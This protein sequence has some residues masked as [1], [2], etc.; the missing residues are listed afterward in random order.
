MTQ[1]SFSGCLFV[2]YLCTSGV[3]AE[4]VRALKSVQGHRI[5]FAPLKSAPVVRGDRVEVI[6]KIPGTDILATAA[7][8]EVTTVGDSSITATLTEISGEVEVGQSVRIVSDLARPPSNSLAP[9]PLESTSEKPD[10]SSV[11]DF[12]KRSLWPDSAAESPA[13]SE[14]APTPI[15]SGSLAQSH[16]GADSR[17]QWLAT[18]LG[19]VTLQH[20]SDAGL[21]VPRGMR[22][23]CVFSEAASGSGKFQV[24]DVVLAAN[25]IEFEPQYHWRR[26]ARLLSRMVQESPRGK[27]MT[28]RIVRD[29]APMILQIR[30]VPR[31]VPEALFDAVSRQAENG[32]PTAQFSLAQFL[33]DG[34]GCKPDPHA[35]IEWLWKSA[36]QEYQPALGRLGECYLTGEGVAVEQNAGLKLLTQA[37]E[38]GDPMFMT[39]LADLLAEGKHLPADQDA[40]FNW[41]YRAALQDDPDAQRELMEIYQDAKEFDEALTWLQKAAEQGDPTC[42]SLLGVWHL[43][44]FQV[45]K[46]AALAVEWFQRAADQGFATAQNNLGSCYHEGTGVAKDPQKAVE[47]FRRAADQGVR[48]AQYNLAWSYENGVG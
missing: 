36:A 6:V 47:F 38:T 8:G 12:F 31:E 34:T 25:E 42:Q 26:N 16:A 27:S 2:M 33:F 18:A 29:R 43:N 46:D 32:N 9:A 11:A 15:E 10:L 14:P 24:G 5:T 13:V 39:R 44:G 22:V 37:A 1:L 28:F 41:Y 19:A 45:R 30:P 4:D 3:V 17:N 23:E 21:D 40:S 48:S 35:A 20:S 7:L